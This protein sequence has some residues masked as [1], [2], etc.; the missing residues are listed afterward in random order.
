[1]ADQSAEFLKVA[2]EAALQAGEIISAA[3]SEAKE[4]EFKGTVDLVTKTDKQCEELIFGVIREAFP[5][6]KF[7]GEEG[8]ASQG[9]TEQLTHEPTW[10]VGEQHPYTL[11]HLIFLILWIQFCMLKSISRSAPS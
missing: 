6:H 1:M 10:L 3:F 8:S 7:I 9:F 4:V 11:H 2:S 5:S